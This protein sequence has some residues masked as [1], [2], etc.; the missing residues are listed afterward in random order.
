[1]LLFWSPALAFSSLAQA[2]QTA[3]CYQPD[4]LAEMQDELRAIANIKARQEIER[5]TVK[6]GDAHTKSR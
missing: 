6:A 1:M 4:L 2:T 3:S 5:E